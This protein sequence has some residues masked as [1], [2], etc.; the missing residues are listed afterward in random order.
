MPGRLQK[1]LESLK[2]RLPPN[3]ESAG[4]RFKAKAVLLYEGS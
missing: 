2:N 4:N 3:G 1:S